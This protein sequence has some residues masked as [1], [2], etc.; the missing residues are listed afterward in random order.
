MKHLLAFAAAAAA[1]A[2]PAIAAPNPNAAPISGELTL[3]AGFRNDP[4]VVSVTAGGTNNAASVANGCAGFISDAPDVRLH[5]KSGSLPLILSV[6]AVGDTTLVVNGPDGRWYCDDDGGAAD[7]P[8]LRIVNPQSGRYE[9]WIG[10]YS[11]GRTEAARL[12]ISEVSSQ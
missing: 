9:I 11:L 1:V 7:N 5:Y 12:H 6:A 2:V 3:S 4:R 8:S 10:T